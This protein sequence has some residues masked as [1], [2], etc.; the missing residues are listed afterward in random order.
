MA[1]AHR[2]LLSSLLL[3]GCGSQPPAPA[4]P[5]WADDVLPILR[6]NCFGCH[7]PTANYKRDMTKRWDVY[8]RNVEPYLR[9]GFGPVT[10]DISDNRGGQFSE[11][12]VLGAKDNAL[13]FPAYVT[14]DDEK[15]RQPPPPASRLSNH[16]IQVLKN[17]VSTSNPD[18]LALGSHHPNHEAAIA[19]LDRGARRVAVTDEDGDTVVGRLDCS[20]TEVALDHSGG[21]TL[22][23]A[24]MLPCRGTL[25]DGFAETAVNLQ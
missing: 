18:R 13:V 14:V 10:E 3:L 19:W 22:P 17:W 21:F 5:T 6:A 11:V 1:P 25:Y 8:D 4:S 24:A 23:E 16:D 20:G 15:A 7:G 9:L 2:W 12:T